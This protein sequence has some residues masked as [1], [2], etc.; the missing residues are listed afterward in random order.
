MAQERIEP[1]FCLPIFLNL[2]SKWLYQNFDS[3]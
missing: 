1:S 3:S 2:A